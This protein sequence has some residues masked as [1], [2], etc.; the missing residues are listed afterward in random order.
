MINMWS[1][2]SNQVPKPTCNQHKLIRIINIR[3]EFH[4]PNFIAT[5]NCRVWYKITSIYSIFRHLAF[6][7]FV[8]NFWNIPYTV[9]HISR[10]CT[11]KNWEKTQNEERNDYS[12]WFWTLFIQQKMW[13]L[14]NG[15]I[16]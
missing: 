16:F 8:L 9:A 5:E 7:H 11:E 4:K 2:V 10:Y 1:V 3:L 15:G 12:E 6:L 13:E 14:Y